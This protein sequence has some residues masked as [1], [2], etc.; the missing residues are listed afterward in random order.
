[1]GY[2]DIGEFWAVVNAPHYFGG[3]SLVISAYAEHSASFD[4]FLDIVARVGDIDGLAC[5][6]DAPRYFGGLSLVISAYA[7]HSASLV[8]FLDVITRVLILV[9]VDAFG[10]GESLFRFQDI[11]I[12]VAV[13]KN[14]MFRHG[15]GVEIGVRR[16]EI[17]DEKG[18]F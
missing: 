7:E 8:E 1:M 13:V 4:E 2:G 11:D 10:D 5:G 16:L 18:E 6:V 15:C 12:I 3:L 9:V 17:G 14:K